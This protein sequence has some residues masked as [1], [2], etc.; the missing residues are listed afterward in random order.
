MFTTKW[1]SHNNHFLPEIIAHNQPVLVKQAMR[2]TH[3]LL[4]SQFYMCL[5]TTPAAAQPVYTMH[6]C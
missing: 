4:P 5:L 2:A 6:D 3:Q 1:A